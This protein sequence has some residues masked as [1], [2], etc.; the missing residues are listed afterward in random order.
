MSD[1]PPAFLLR[2]ADWTQRQLDRVWQR[3]E[4]PVEELNDEALAA[5]EEA[6]REE[7]ERFER[8]WGIYYIPIALVVVLWL[9]AASVWDKV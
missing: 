5:R 7:A 1:T 2:A 9:I 3:G 8:R 6:A 4:E